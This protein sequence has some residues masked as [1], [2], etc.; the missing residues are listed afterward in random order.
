MPSYA[1]LPPP[2]SHLAW[3]IVFTFLGFFPFGI[4][5][6]IKAGTVR[7]L[8]SQGRWGE[9]IAASRSARRWVIAAVLTVPG[10]FLALST[11]LAVGVALT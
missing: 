7:P 4:V 11:L 8:W 2:P 10:F 5:A 1:A 6:I 9:S 3:A